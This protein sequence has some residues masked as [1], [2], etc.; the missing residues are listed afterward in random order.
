MTTVMARVKKTAA[1]PRVFL[2]FLIVLL[3]VLFGSL[4]PAF[5]NGPFVLAPLMS[6]IAIF[7]VVGLAQMVALSVGHMNLAVGQMAS[8]G[9]MVM[10]LCYDVF[11]MPLILGLL[12]GLVAGAAVGALTGW[13]IVKTGV[14]S[15]IVTLAMS[16]ALIGLVPAMYSWLSEGAAFTSKPAGLDLIGRQTFASICMGNTCGTDAVPLII[17]PAILIMGLVWY[18]YSRTRLGREIL[19]TG[20]NVKAAELSGVPTG[21]RLMFVH[22]LSGT[23]AAAAGFMVAASVGSF[24]PAIGSEFMLP[25]FVGPI[26]GG[27]LLAGGFVSVIGTFLGIT[28][29]LV[30]RKGLDLFGVGLETMN[31]LLGVILLVALSTERFR[32]ASGGRRRGGERPSGEPAQTDDPDQPDEALKDPPESV[33]TEDKELAR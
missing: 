13:I 1:N 20:S 12:V 8:L 4:K 19:V 30:I 11:R 2:L 15:F 23:L 29:T 9:A 6:S 14:N 17:L 18:L 27:T 7:T 28:L 25:S 5:L 24:T 26:L 31:V 22:T 21:R 16:F 3:V 32:L 10:G 33:Q